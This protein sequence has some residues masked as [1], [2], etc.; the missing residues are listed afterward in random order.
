M[1]DTVP[2]SLPYQTPALLELGPI[3]KLTAGQPIDDGSG[4]LSCPDGR[5][6]I[7]FPGGP[8]FCDDRTFE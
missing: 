3:H 1:S 8:P 2:Q 7:S 4:N 5:Q 6:L